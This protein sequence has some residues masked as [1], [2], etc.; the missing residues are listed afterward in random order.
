MSNIDQAIERF[1]KAHTELM[2]SAHELSE[3]LEK[4][5]APSKELRLSAIRAA[6][7]FGISA[8][9]LDAMKDTIIDR[10]VKIRVVEQ[11]LN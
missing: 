3:L 5:E 7:R 2:E 1:V 6:G 9:A 8:R 4:S 11:G 10:E